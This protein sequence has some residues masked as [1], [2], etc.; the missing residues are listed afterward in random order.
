LTFTA[1]FDLPHNSAHLAILPARDG[2]DESPPIG[3]DG[4]RKRARGARKLRASAPKLAFDVTY[5]M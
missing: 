4:Y 5:Y 2:D 1:W 3:N